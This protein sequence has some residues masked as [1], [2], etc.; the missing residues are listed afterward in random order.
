MAFL[1]M[2]FCSETVVL[3]PFLAGGMGISSS[4][5]LP[6]GQPGGMGC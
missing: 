2:I 6:G 3:Q 4:K 1:H 5:K